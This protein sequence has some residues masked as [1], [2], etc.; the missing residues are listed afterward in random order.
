MPLSSSFTPSLK[1]DESSKSAVPP[2]LSQL[3][4]PPTVHHPYKPKN[5]CDDIPVVVY[6]LEMVENSHIREAEELLYTCDP[7]GCGGLANVT[8]TIH[9]L[10]YTGP[11][12]MS[13]RATG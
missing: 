2:V 3:D 5:A 9:T 4:K 12:F 11:V 7:E 1:L 8:R 13:L 6:A 10:P